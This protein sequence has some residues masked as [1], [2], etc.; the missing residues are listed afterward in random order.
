MALHPQKVEWQ[1][2]MEP[3]MSN[4]A[5]V[6]L[7]VK[8]YEL[9]ETQRGLLLSWSWLKW[10]GIAWLVFHRVRRVVPLQMHDLWASNGE[11]A[12]KFWGFATYRSFF[13]TWS[14]CAKRKWKTLKV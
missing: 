8:D 3:H 6:K 5:Q 1:R 10:R 12:L 11:D 14:G 9:K 7:L 13:A 4:S 2:P